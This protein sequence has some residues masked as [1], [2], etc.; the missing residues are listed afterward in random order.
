MEEQ[1]FSI[2]DVVAIFRRNIRLVV[3]VAGGVM[4]AS[5]F[6][7]AILRDE[8]TVATTLLV[9]PQS[10]SRKLVETSEE[11]ADVMNRLHLMT[12]QILSRARLSKVIDDLKLYPEESE[13]KTREEVIDMMRGR[14]HVEP[15]L[16]EIADP[17]LKRRMEI[18]VNTF[19]LYFRHENAGTAAAVANRLANDFIDEH[20]KERVQSSGD[21]ADFVDSELQRV[22]GR[23]RELEAQIAQVKAQNAGSLPE[24]VLANQR[25][26]ERAFDQLSL[27]SQRLAEARSDQAFY[28]QQA[29][30]ARET[31]VGAVAGQNNNVLSPSQ[32]LQLLENELGEL[33]GRGFTDRHPDVVAKKAEMEQVRARI[34]GGDGGTERAPIATSAQEQNALN[35]AKRAALQVEA[36][37]REVARLQEQMNLAQERLANTPR[38]AEQLDALEREYEQLTASFN[39]FSAKR[40]EASVAANMERRQKGEQFRVLE[41]AYPPPDPTSPNRPLILALGVMLGIG[42]GAGLALLLDAADSSYHGAR[43]LQGALRI[44]V[45]S[46]IPSILLDAD[47][48]RMRRRNLRDAFA[49]VAVSGVVLTSAA[50]GYVVVNKPHWLRGGEETPPA[51]A[52]AP[53]PA[54]PAA[55]AAAA[56]GQTG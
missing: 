13:E 6:I 39:D 32:R 40:L 4:L 20:I 28:N 9:E 14:I 47:R 22:A 23:L 41:P 42:A 56:P 24:D 44:P 31:G 46:A 8:F 27:A 55:P 16:P 2:K 49:A 19:R 43:Q 25:Q 53:V 3:A 30:V 11:E 52:P 1:G 38:V 34:K 10:I 15:V 33:L 45:L 51:A 35:E 12:M 48:A 54:P 18:D 26:V 17:D 5:V 36:G 37:E 50:V 21:T 7:A 29:I